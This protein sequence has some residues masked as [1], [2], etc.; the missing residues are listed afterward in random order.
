MF[1]FSSSFFCLL[2]VAPGIIRVHKQKNKRRRGNS[3]VRELS[4]GKERAEKSLSRESKRLVRT[5]FTKFYFFKRKINWLVKVWCFGFTISFQS[6]ESGGSSY[7]PN[8]RR[9]WYHADHKYSVF[10]QID[11]EK[12]SY[13]IL[14]LYSSSSIFLD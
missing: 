6:L 5:M 10:S 14:F 12:N 1:D 2:L 11:T 3:A 7:S 4:N 8:L 9:L 13:G